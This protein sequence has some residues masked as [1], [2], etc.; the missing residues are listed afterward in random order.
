[1]LT[2]KDSGPVATKPRTP[3][4]PRTLAMRL[5]AEEYQRFVVQ[6]RELSP[7]DW[8]RP[9]TCPEWDVHAMVAHVLGMAEMSASVPEQLRQTRAAKK[10]GGLFIDALTA[11]QVDKHVHRSPAELV[12]RLAT[13]GP[14]AAAGRRRTPAPLRRVRLAGQP[15]EETGTLTEPWTVGYLTDV[16]LTRDTW[17]HR[18]DIAV[19]T[20]QP[21]TLTPEHDGAIVADVAQEW[22]VRHGRPCTL[23]LTGPAGGSWT[24][25]PGA[26]SSEAVEHQLDAVDFCRILS[27]RGS[28]PGLL[29]T[30]VPF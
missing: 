12:D 13:V 19:A 21:M 28:G 5:A 30:R 10:R 29:G 23:T 24:F 6:L 16:I 22:A 20:G 3:L 9:T 8:S 2:T 14:K 25:N 11:L 18:S 4:L 17:M 27:G 26:A 1:M 15:V 7:D